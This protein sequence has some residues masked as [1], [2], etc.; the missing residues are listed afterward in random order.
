[1]LVATQKGMSE[2]FL[3]K[4][5][6]FYANIGRN[7][8]ELR[9]HSDYSDITLACDGNQ[10][11][12]VHKLIISASSEIFKEMLV[13]Y[14]NSNPLIYLRGITAN[15][16]N[17]I[18]DFIYF[19]EANVYQEDLDRFL[20]LAEEFKVKGLYGQSQSINNSGTE[21]VTT[22]PE[23]QENIDANVK[24]PENIH[25]T[26]NYSRNQQIKHFPSCSNSKAKQIAI[27]EEEQDNLNTNIKHSNE[28][29]EQSYS[30]IHQQSVKQE[31]DNE[32]SKVY[33]TEILASS[34]ENTLSEMEEL[35]KTIESMAEKRVSGWT[36]KVCEKVSVRK[37]NIKK[38]TEVHIEGIKR[39][40]L[41]CGK[42]F[43]SQDSLSVHR[44]T[45][46]SNTIQYN[47][48]IRFRDTN[49]HL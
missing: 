20:A 40:C 33:N 43:K 22:I 34:I 23:E 2:K 1:M 26:S 37:D 14:N 36:C 21:T 17:S 35:E 9:E 12:K 48:K 25:N 39:P 45:S 29:N 3:L 47:N 18:I 4:W 10:Q 19:G 6:E 32:I 49:T 38:H 15:D 7:Y 41:T 46:H 42:I 11:F 31:V 28:S 44:A 13:S 24:H 16:L 5:K 8:K 30:L 27:I